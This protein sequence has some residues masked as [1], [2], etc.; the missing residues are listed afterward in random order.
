MNN[1]PDVTM[2]SNG[3][4]QTVTVTMSNIGSAPAPPPRLT[5]TLPDD[6]KTV[7]A[8]STGAGEAGCP[9]GKGQVTC[10]AGELGAGESVRF[11][12][13]LNAGPKAAS[14]VITGVTDTGLRVRFQVTVTPK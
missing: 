3:P 8:G 11:V 9:A 14:G 10:S 13:R 2:A 6:I 1:P 12:L 5:L 7:G 4:P